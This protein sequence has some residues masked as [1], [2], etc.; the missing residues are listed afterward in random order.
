[1][2][3][4]AAGLPR[5]GTLSQKVA[6]EMLGLAPCCH[7]VNLLG[8]LNEAQVWRRAHEGEAPWQEILDGFEATVGW[9][10]SFFYKELVAAYPHAKVLLSVRDAEGWEHSMRETIWG[11]FFGDMLIRD[12]SSAWTRVDSK[13][14]GYIELMKEMWQSSGLVS[15]AADTKPESIKSAMA[16]FNEEVQQTVPSERLLVWSVSDGWEPL[17]RF[18][19]IAVPDPPSRIRTT[20]RSS[21]NASSMDRSWRCRS[22]GPRDAP[23]SRRGV[24]IVAPATR[25]IPAADSRA[26]RS[27]A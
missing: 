15:D 7:T 12:L 14:H 1:M 10:G 21:P 11:I 27:R 5:S 23:G 18:L 2:R 13:W 24:S 8:D 6:L 16:R 22:G 19:D 17:C 9:P 4:I 20:A 3:L 26:G 25:D